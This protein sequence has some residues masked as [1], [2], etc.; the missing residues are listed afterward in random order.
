MPVRIDT[1]TIAR[2]GASGN[3][4]CSIRYSRSAP[5]HT[6]ITTSLSVP[7]VAS[8]RRLR[9]SSDSERIANRRC[10]LTDLFHGVAG[11]ALTGTWTVDV[12]PVAGVVALERTSGGGRAGRAAA[13]TSDARR[14]REVT[15][16]LEPQASSRGTG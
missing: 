6:A 8:F 10:A 3:A 13:R 11:A 4:S 2:S 1:G 14:V 5:A 16:H 15:H 12:A 7:P 9:L